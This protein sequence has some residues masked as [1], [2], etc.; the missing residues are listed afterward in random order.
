MRS[1]MPCL[2]SSLHPKQ[3]K[4]KQN[5]EER[6]VIPAAKPIKSSRFSVYCEWLCVYI[7]C[8]TTTTTVFTQIFHF[9]ALCLSHKMPFCWRRK[10]SD[11][12]H[13]GAT[14]GSLFSSMVVCVWQ[15]KFRMKTFERSKCGVTHTRIVVDFIFY[16][17]AMVCNRKTSH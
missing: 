10:T 3:S 2:S 6:K 4:T 15:Y 7:S 9:Y 8:C 1:C 13:S 17:V 16:M 12:N 5:E 14:R 11:L